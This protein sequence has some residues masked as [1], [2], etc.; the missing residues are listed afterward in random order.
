M[1]IKIIPFLFLAFTIISCSSSNEKPAVPNTSLENTRWVLRSLNELKVF[2]PESGKEAFITLMSSENRARGNAGCNTF[3]GTYTVTKNQ[4]KFG[5]IA[6]T[7][8]YCEQQMQT[9][10]NFVKAL[11]SANKFKIRGDKL[12]LYDS[13]QLLA[14]FEAVY[15]N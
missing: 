9:E 15:L 10:N 5:P 2:T 11:E 12:Y 7:E 13:I 3:F 14:T 4:I 8:M 6:R 1:H